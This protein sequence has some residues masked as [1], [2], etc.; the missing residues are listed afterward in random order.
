MTMAKISTSLNMKSNIN[1]VRRN[2]DNL[3]TALPRIGKFRIT[4]AL[5]EIMRRMSKP[6]K[7]M[8]YPVPWVNVK[9]RI[10]VIIMIMKKQGFLPYART[11]SHERGWKMESNVQGGKVYNN[12]RGSKHLYGTMRDPRQSPIHVGRWV[13]LRATYDAVVKGLPKKVKESLRKVP[14]A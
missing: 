13:N 6:G 5:T 9:Q 14:R 8:T 11:G 7:K 3:R 10:K 12:S 2:L 1:L 4:E